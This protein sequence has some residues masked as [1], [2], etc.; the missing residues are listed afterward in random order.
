M[1][2]SSS[3]VKLLTTTLS[4]DSWSLKIFRRTSGS[5]VTL[6]LTAVEPAPVK[7]EVLAPLVSGKKPSAFFSATSGAKFATEASDGSLRFTPM[8]ADVVLDV[9]LRTSP[10]RATGVTFTEAISQPRKT[11]ETK[12]ASTL[13]EIQHKLV[14]LTF[15]ETVEAGV[16]GAIISPKKWMPYSTL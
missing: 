15:R 12:V 4:T 10:P 14:L 1:L 16:V 3:S 2:S 9:K 6:L 11:S 8:G 13:A 7:L 5:T